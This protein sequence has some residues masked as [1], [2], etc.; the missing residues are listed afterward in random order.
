MFICLIYFSTLSIKMPIPTTATMAVITAIPAD[1][2][3]RSPDLLYF[4]N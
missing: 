1:L 3:M 2:F 4:V